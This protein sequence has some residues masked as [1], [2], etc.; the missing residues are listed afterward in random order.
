[1]ARSVS[2]VNARR[3]LG[4]LA[5]EVNRTGRP[6]ILTRRG[7]V[8]ARIAPEPSAVVPGAPGYDAFAPLRGTV[9]LNCSFDELRRAI[10]GLR[11][12]FGRNLESRVPP[13]A[14]RRRA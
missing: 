11:K 5:E 10:R 1:M 14:P 7:R 3:R 12:E 13:K 4:R 6:I 8:V 9:R 2:I